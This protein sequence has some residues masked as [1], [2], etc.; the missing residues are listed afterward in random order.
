MAGRDPWSTRLPQFYW[1]LWRHFPAWASL[2]QC[3]EPASPSWHP[4][5]FRNPAVSLQVSHL[6]NAS[7]TLL[8]SSHSD[9]LMA[10]GALAASCVSVHAG[11]GQLQLGGGRLLTQLWDPLCLPDEHLATVG[12]S[13]AARPQ[14]CHL[15]AAGPAGPLAVRGPSTPPTL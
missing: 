6:Q 9:P 11:P 2:S 8:F 14:G 3:T 13:T 7:E 15:P 4:T 12:M 5:G 1:H 10:T